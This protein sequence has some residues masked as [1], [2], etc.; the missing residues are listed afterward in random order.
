MKGNDYI[1]VLKYLEE[2]FTEEEEK[3]DLKQPK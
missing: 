1:K 2:F 3:A